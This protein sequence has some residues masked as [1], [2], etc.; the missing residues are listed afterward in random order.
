VSPSRSSKPPKEQTAASTPDAKP[1]ALD[2]YVQVGVVV[3][4]HS[5]D[6]RLR[7]LPQTANPQR[8]RPRA[9]IHIK[10]QRFVVARVQTQQHILLVKLNGIDSPEAGA[11]LVREP[12]FVPERAVPKPPEGTYYHYQIID[13]DVVAESGEPLGRLVEVLETGANDVFVVRDE[14]QEWLLPAIGD[15]VVEVDLA[16][17]RMRVA[18]P[19]GLEPRPVAAPKPARPLRPRRRRSHHRDAGQAPQA[20]APPQA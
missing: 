19:Q 5:H 14:R 6:G 18:I 4:T 3:G 15:V 11:E 20:P 9:A 12:V 17:R 16:A 8:F 1:A 7:I 10:G 13:M 2:A